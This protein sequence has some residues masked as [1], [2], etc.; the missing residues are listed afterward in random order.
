MGYTTGTNALTV[1][2]PDG[3]LMTIAGRGA[4]FWRRLPGGDWKCVIDIWNSG[5]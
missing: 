1:P 5:P 3:K 2:G 4:A